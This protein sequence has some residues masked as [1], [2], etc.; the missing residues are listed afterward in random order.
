MR[1]FKQGYIYESN[2][3]AKLETEP[4]VRRWPLYILILILIT[5]ITLH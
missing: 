1:E 5:A 3:N 2:P 4:E